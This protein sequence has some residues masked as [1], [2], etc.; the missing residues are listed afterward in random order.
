MTDSG[1]LHSCIKKFMEEE[2]IEPGDGQKE[3][4]R[5]ERWI[6]KLPRLLF[7]DLSRFQ[8]DSSSSI[9]VKV[10]SVIQYPEVLYMDRYMLENRRMMKD[11]QKGLK[12]NGFRLR[13]V[14]VHE[15]SANHGHYWTFVSD[16]S[17]KN[18]MKFDDKTVTL[19][20]L[21]QVKEEGEGG[22]GKMSAYSLVY[23][24]IASDDG[25]GFSWDQIDLD[26]ALKVTDD[27]LKFEEELKQW[28]ETSANR[29]REVR[30]RDLADRRKLF[31]HILSSGALAGLRM[32]ASN[33]ERVVDIYSNLFA[34]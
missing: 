14:M 30:H 27:N 18:W 21:D 17:G 1:D 33:S 3:G 12:C 7:I 31:K 23:S 34:G 22:K 24:D 32:E 11:E 25:V 20:S 2:E 16:E 28:D 26:L 29:N 8:F 9:T 19:S 4:G 6:E 5:Q 15:G 13:A 10:D